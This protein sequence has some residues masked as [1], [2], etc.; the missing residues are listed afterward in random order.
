MAEPSI[1]L[2]RLIGE[3]LAAFDDLLELVPA[4]NI[5]DRT[6][7]P[8]VVPCVVIGDAHTVFADFHANVYATIH[9]WTAEPGLGLSKEIGG[10][11]IDALAD[12]PWPLDGW[13]CH[14]LT[15]TGS[16][17]LRDPDGQHS[18]GVLSFEAVVQERAT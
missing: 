2:Q 9:V 4:A 6:G 5:L 16:R 18:H 12:G 3:R 11:V 14:D 13:L 8:E 10:A 1:A 7:R 15:V 17:Y